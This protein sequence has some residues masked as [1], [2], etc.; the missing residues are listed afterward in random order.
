MDDTDGREAGSSDSDDSEADDDT[1]EELEVVD[2]ATWV[3][4]IVR[5]TD[6]AEN[7][8]RKAK[9]TDWA[10]EQR[11]RKWRWAGHVMRRVDGRWSRKVLERMPEAGCRKVGRPVK[12]WADSILEYLREGGCE[13]WAEQAADRDTWEKM[14]PGFAARRR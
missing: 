3:K 5:V 11:K 7:E 13:S 2:E 9:I 6:I 1:N 8:A 12:R 10:Q 14:C 4:W